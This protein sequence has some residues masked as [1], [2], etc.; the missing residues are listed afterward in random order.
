MNRAAAK[1]LLAK[2]Q[3]VL[4]TCACGGVVVA[5]CECMTCYQRRRRKRIKAGAPR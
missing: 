2:A 5:H 4:K 3:A 1:K